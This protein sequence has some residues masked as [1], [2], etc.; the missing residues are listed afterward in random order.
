M[1]ITAKRANFISIQLSHQL[2]TKEGSCSRIR[3]GYERV[4]AHRVSNLYAYT[5]A[6]DGKVVEVNQESQMCKIQYKDGSIHTFQFGELYGECA[7]MVTT[8]KLTLTIKV[9]DKFNKGDVLCYNPQFFELDPASRQVDWKHGVSAMVA[10][11]DCAGTFEDSNIITKKFG[12]KLEIEPVQIRS[13]S[14]SANTFVHAIKKIGDQVDINDYLIVFEDA[15]VTD[16]SSVTT[17]DVALDYLA[18]LNRVTPKAKFTGEIVKIEV[19]YSCPVNEMHPTLSKIV[20]DI[21]RLNNA[22]NKFSQGTS[23]SAQYPSSQP[24]P[25]GTK[26]KKVKFEKDTVVIRFFIKESITAGVG[27]KI[28]FDSSLKSVVG[29]VVEEGP[30]TESGLE[31]DAVFSGSS[32]SNRIVNSPILVGVGE[33]VLEKLEESIVDLYFK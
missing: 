14:F 28:V 6:Q 2:P 19:F 30:T 25:E 9:G 7:D 16:M 5:A 17:D 3:T 32:I 29:V 13:I 33:R 31:V 10:L 12:E 4:I 21:I 1:N 18:K 27:D 20:K 23:S 24:L 15:T 11:M 26:F 22:K 8:Q